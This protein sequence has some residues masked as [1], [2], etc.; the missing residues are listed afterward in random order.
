[1]DADQSGKIATEKFSKKLGEKRTVIVN[2]RRFNKDGPKDANDCL[3]MGVSIKKLIEEASLSVNENITT[4]SDI[5]NDVIQFIT[6]FELYTGYKSTSFAFFNE[7]LKGLRM[8]EF[9]IFTGETGSGKTTF[10]TQ[11]ALDFLNQV[12]YC[13]N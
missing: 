4:F 11:L 7:N 6:Q 8:G 12:Y 2:P 5:R 9:T 3:K 13:N 1:M 10:L